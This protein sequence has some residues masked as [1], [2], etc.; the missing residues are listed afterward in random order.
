MNETNETLSVTSNIVQSITDVLEGLNKD[1]LVIP[2]DPKEI[3][4]DIIA[5][6]NQKL[7]NTVQGVE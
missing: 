5:M 4:N 2:N 1:N 3:A 7:S 6:I